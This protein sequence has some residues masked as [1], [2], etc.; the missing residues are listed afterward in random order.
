MPDN[1][2]DINYTIVDT[3]QV[4]E[5]IAEFHAFQRAEETMP[6]GGGLEELIREAANHMPS[7]LLKFEQD[8]NRKIQLL[9]ALP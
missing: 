5:C 1:T 3:N 8:V 4:M 2:I 6:Q 9:D 7:E